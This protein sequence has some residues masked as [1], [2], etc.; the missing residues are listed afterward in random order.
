[1]VN[2]SCWSRRLYGFGSGLHRFRKCFRGNVNLD[3][4]ENGL[5]LPA[6]NRR[7]FVQGLAASAAVAAAG[8]DGA[9]AFGAVLPNV[10][11]TLSGK[12]FEL[13]IDY[14]PVNFTGKR[15]TAMAVNGSVPGPLL[16]W[17][18]GDHVSITVT[19][20]LKEPTSLHWHSLRIPAEMDGVPGLSFA[21]I[22]PGETFH[23]H[24]QVKQHGTAWYHSHTRFQEQS[25]LRGPLIID[26]A[27]EDPIQ[28]DREHVIFLSDWTD[29]DPETVFSN[30]KE[31]SD[32]YNYHRHTLPEFLSTAKRRG[33]MRTI[34]ERLTW[35]RM[36]MSSSDISDVSAATY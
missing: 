1:M 24:F 14:L 2:A 20:R 31:Q 21:G 28:S 3:D 22:A 16:R 27:G 17:R 8:W 35:A 9:P 12:H 23:Y 30:L 13:T 32:Y 11:R 10:P 7:R 19:N 18:E 33:L 26:P 36:N 15:V 6:I 29:S 4:A 25:G 34:K 5:R